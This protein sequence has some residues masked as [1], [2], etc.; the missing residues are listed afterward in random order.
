MKMRYS[1]TYEESGTSE[2]LWDRL[3]EAKTLVNA[4]PFVTPNYPTILHSCQSSHLLVEWGIF[5]V[6][7]SASE[8]EEY[9]RI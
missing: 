7:V 4:F 1:K 9:G 2:G 5:E 8:F 6:G 3:G